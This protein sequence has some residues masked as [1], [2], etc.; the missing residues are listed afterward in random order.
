MI[1]VQIRSDDA[2]RS[3][4]F[5]SSVAPVG[6]TWRLVEPAFFTSHVHIRSASGDVVGLACRATSARVMRPVAR[7]REA[8][9]LMIRVN[10]RLDVVRKSIG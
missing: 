1:L 4:R 3:A 10:P 7:E 8:G 9:W 2:N 6:T 5:S